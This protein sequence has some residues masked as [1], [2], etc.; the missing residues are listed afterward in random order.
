MVRPLILRVVGGS[1]P[2]LL[3]LVT[4]CSLLVSTTGLAGEAVAADA[5]TLDGATDVATSDDAADAAVGDAAP[6]PAGAVVWSGNGHAY[7]VVVTG[8]ANKPT[9]PDARDDAKQRG[10]HLATIT[11]AGENAF[12]FSP[13]QARDDAWDGDFGALLGGSK[14]HGAPTDG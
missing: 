9:W 3:I 1:A 6:L 7:L 11:S 14:P 12:V 2:L 5:S 4:S 8:A 13:L 10:G